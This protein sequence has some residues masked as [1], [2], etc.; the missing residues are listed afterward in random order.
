MEMFLDKLNIREV[1]INDIDNGLLD[2]Y[3]DGYKFHMHGRPDIF[4]ELNEEE[5]KKDL[6]NIYDMKKIIVLTYNDYVI[7]YLSYTI[8]KRHTCKLDVDQLVIKEEYRGKGL[9][10]KLMDEIK[11]IA[12]DN[13][14]DR[15]ELN[16]WMFNESALKMYE[17]IGY[18]KQRIM[19][20]MKLK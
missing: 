5:M 1:N 7:G 4:V 9:G 2:V 13:N 12:L 19:F 17:H 18:E 15:I 11:K 20:E 14:C 6:L 8:K 10:K 16:C 3:I